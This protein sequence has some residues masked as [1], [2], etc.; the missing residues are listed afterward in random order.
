MLAAFAIFS[1]AAGVLRSGSGS[2]SGSSRYSAADATVGDERYGSW[3]NTGSVSVWREGRKTDTGGF[4]PGKWDNKGTAMVFRPESEGGDGDDGYG[5]DGYGRSDSVASSSYMPRVSSPFSDASTDSAATSRRPSSPSDAPPMGI[6]TPSISSGIAR[7]DHE[8]AKPVGQRP[9]AQL[10]RRAEIVRDIEREKELSDGRFQ[11]WREE[12]WRRKQEDQANF[13][14][15]RNERTGETLTGI[16]RR[17]YMRW[18]SSVAERVRERKHLSNAGRTADAI[19]LF[20][21]TRAQKDQ[22][23]ATSEREILE[24]YRSELPAYDSAPQ[25]SVDEYARRIRGQK[26]F[27]WYQRQ[28]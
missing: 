8:F 26:E 21:H 6:T 14:G 2:R 27:G 22:L 24:D 25:E 28:A 20:G 18:L 1:A 11:A 13:P 10:D 23:G 7:P 12:M 15:P 9:Q 16:G 4:Q 3:D 17:Q 19:G 5:Y